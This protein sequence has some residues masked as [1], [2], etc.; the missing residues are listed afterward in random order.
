MFHEIKFKDLIKT[1]AK[2]QREIDF[3]KR[4][5]NDLKK[6]KYTRS[7]RGANISSG[8]ISSL[9]GLGRSNAQIS[10]ALMKLLF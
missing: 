8:I 10:K 2:Q 3:L 5:L 1:L 6:E 9:P 4:S 7:K